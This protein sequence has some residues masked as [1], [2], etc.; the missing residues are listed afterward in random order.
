MSASS[1]LMDLLSS[2]IRGGI[3]P[4]KLFELYIP[5]FM[6]LRK[7]FSTWFRIDLSKVMSI[8][9]F[10]LLYMTAGRSMF[11]Q[12]YEQFLGYFTSTVSIPSDD[13]EYQQ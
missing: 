4:E 5:G 7:L 1:S 3:E 8:A 11:G 10:C 2:A 9:F 12:A 13:R 6:S